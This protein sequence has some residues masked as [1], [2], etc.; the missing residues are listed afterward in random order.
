MVGQ[1]IRDVEDSYARL[2]R[3]DEYCTIRTAGDLDELVDDVARFGVHR[4]LRDGLLRVRG[5]ARLVRYDDVESC[6]VKNAIQK[7]GTVQSEY[8]P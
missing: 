1:M 3:E 7:V 5:G 6:V 2:E 4:V 8:E